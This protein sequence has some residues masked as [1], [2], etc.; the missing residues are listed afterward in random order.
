MTPTP[1][2]SGKTDMKKYILFGIALVLLAAFAFVYVVYADDVVDSYSESNKDGGQGL[3][4]AGNTAYAQ[5]FQP[6][7]DY[8]LTRADFYLSK[9]GSPTGNAVAKLYA[10]TGTFGTDAEPTGAALDTSNNLDV[11][12]ISSSPTYDLHTFTFTGEY[13]MTSGTTYVITVEYSGGDASNNVVV[14]R[15][16]S[17]PT[18]AGNN[19]RFISGTWSQLAGLD[20]VFYVYGT[21][22]AAPATSNEISLQTG[23]IQVRS[24]T[25]HIQ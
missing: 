12:T 9:T 14:G 24:G 3:F 22:P 5:S 13:P 2:S 8:P 7:A 17:S 1:S 25:I 19:S 18:H 21:T 11:S 16:A 6:P 15:D 23:S 20:F 4:G 10:S